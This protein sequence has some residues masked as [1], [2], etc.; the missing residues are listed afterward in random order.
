MTQVTS[1]SQSTFNT[2]VSTIKNIDKLNDPTLEQQNNQNNLTTKK[3]SILDAEAK[4]TNLNNDLQT[5]RSNL[6]LSK[7]SYETQIKQ[8]QNDIQNTQNNLAV[9]K[10]SLKDLQK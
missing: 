5:L 4:L 10:E 7:K 9:Y 2:I 8:K 6:E 1:S 3:N